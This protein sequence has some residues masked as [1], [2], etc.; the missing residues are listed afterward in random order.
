MIRSTAPH[1]FGTAVAFALLVGTA[2]ISGCAGSKTAVREK[3]SQEW[4]DQGSRLAAKEKYDEALESFREAARGYRGADLDADIQ[5]ALADASFNKKDYAVAVEAYT[6]FLRLHPHNSRADYA[7]FRIG[8]C[9]QKQMRSADRSQEPARKAVDAYEALL[10]G[11]PRSALLEQGRAGLTV[12]RRRI[13][14]HELY[15]AAF[16]RRTEKYLAAAGRYELVLREYADL[17]YADQALF[18]L[19]SCYRKLR[20]QEKADRFFDQLRREYPGSRFLKDLDGS[21]G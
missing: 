20:E 13:A 15:V 10:R 4:Y 17:G 8:L 18:E 14:D 16:Y 12:A 11:Y 7:Q 6:E 3:T 9:W 19:G 5:I 2:A 21:K 1:R